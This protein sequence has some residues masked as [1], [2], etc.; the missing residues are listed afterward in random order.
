M[1]TDLYGKNSSHANQNENP[2]K[3]SKENSSRLKRQLDFGSASEE[4]NDKKSGRK[5]ATTNATETQKKSTTRNQP[6]IL[7]L[8]KIAGIPV[9]SASSISDSSSSSS[10]SSSEETKTD[11][12]L[13]K[14]NG[15]YQRKAIRRT[16]P[17]YRNL[18][19]VESDNDEYDHS[20]GNDRKNFT[21]EVVQVKRKVVRKEDGHIPSHFAK[22]SYRI[23]P[24]LKKVSKKDINNKP[25][26]IY[27]RSSSPR[28][29]DNQRASRRL[30]KASQE[31][32]TERSDRSTED[33]EEEEEDDDEEDRRENTDRNSSQEKRVVIN[34]KEL[35]PHHERD[36]SDE[37]LKDY[38]DGHST[39][40]SK[41]NFTHTII[42]RNVAGF[43]PNPGGQAIQ[44]DTSHELSK[45]AGRSKDARKIVIE[46]GQVREKYAKENSRENSN[47]EVYSV[48]G[49][50]T[51]ST[52]NYES[53]KQAFPF[54]RNRSSKKGKDGSGS[55]KEINDR[56]S[57]VIRS[58]LEELYRKGHPGVV[59]APRGQNAASAHQRHELA[60]PYGESADEGTPFGYNPLV[61]EPPLKFDPASDRFYGNPVPDNKERVAQSNSP[62]RAE[63]RNAGGNRPRAELDYLKPAKRSRSTEDEDAPE[64]VPVNEEGRATSSEAPQE[65]PQNRHPNNDRFYY[66]RAYNSP[67][68]TADYDNLEQGVNRD[69]ENDLPSYDF[70][71]L[72]ESFDSPH[73]GSSGDEFFD[74]PGGNDFRPRAGG[75]SQD[76]S[77]ERPHSPAGNDYDGDGGERQESV[78]PR[79]PPAPPSF[80]TRHSDVEYDNNDS[81]ERGRGG[82][83]PVP[84]DGETDDEPDQDSPSEN[85]ETGFIET[86][87]QFDEEIRKLQHAGNIRHAFI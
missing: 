26:V 10:S 79:P 8:V 3:E 37:D 57:P 51:S 31:V 12:G 7:R 41:G 47:P 43:L 15:K 50:R 46:R 65:D 2:S 54:E 49:G 1:F 60:E 42:S 68:Y 83:R 76:E 17:K 81:R 44:S 78:R 16:R 5:I 21:F 77:S 58:S 36:L 25:S 30:G 52:E 75:N 48:P 34:S 87:K 80:V 69:Q 72:D 63:S 67:D 62:V 24:R 61:D 84:N 73:G 53:T 33:A 82:F 35:I 6:P 14:E 28:A 39:F 59:R 38:H 71:G 9:R 86:L 27:R 64:V 45:R 19:S 29:I 66:G 18:A 56:T 20:P 4:Q 13:K 85:D 11:D 22:S 40:G 70:V 74:F 55:S 23:E 32:A